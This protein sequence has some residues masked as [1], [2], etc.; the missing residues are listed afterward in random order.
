[1]PNEV[2]TP[3]VWAEVDVTLMTVDVVLTPGRVTPSVVVD[4]LFLQLDA[5]KINE[6][7]TD[8]EIV[9]E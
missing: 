2:T 7:K 9:V 3:P 8:R 6:K 4:E 5:I 1:L